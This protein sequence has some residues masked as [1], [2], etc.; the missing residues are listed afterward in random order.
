MWKA[1]TLSALAPQWLAGLNLGLHSAA[2][3]GTTSVMLPPDMTFPLDPHSIIK[4][5]Q[6]TGATSLLTPPSLIEACYHDDT[7]FNFLKTLSY[8]S[9]CGAPL[10]EKVGDALAQHTQLF[11]ITGSTECGGHISFGSEDISMWNTFEFVPE[12]GPRFEQ[13]SDD[14]YEL[15]IDRTP[16]SDIF[17]GAFYTF[18]D[19]NTVSTGELY[20]PLVDSAGHQRWIYRGR[21]DDL[22]KLSWLAK[23][24]ASHIEAEIARHPNVRSVLVGGEGREVPYI[25][26]EPKD[27]STISNKNQF[28]DEIYDTII[29]DVN[30]KDNAEIS[31]PRETVMLSDPAL[32]FKRTLKMTIMR[33]EVETAYRSY[34]D[35][36]Y[37]Q[38][39]AKKK[40]G[41]ASNSQK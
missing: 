38:W 36:M 33:K 23:F 40:S 24:H 1:L 39:E 22:V 25:I 30:A 29:S 37:Q 11:P 27:W 41:S 2:F 4:I 7:A 34:I 26:I 20:S 10:D 15:H 9:W 35:G 32:P 31:I 3:F 18:P 28:V 5:L 8:V 6:H 21:K 16:E 13:I 14:I 12:M 17:Q 19:K